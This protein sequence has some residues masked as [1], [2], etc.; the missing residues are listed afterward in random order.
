[1]QRNLERRRGTAAEYTGTDSGCRCRNAVLRSLVFAAVLVAGC[2][3]AELPAFS[4]PSA[5]APSFV[6]T[7]AAAFWQELPEIERAAGAP[8]GRARLELELPGDE[9]REGECVRSRVS[10]V[11][12]EGASWDLRV[13]PHCSVVREDP[14]LGVAIAARSPWR[15][16]RGEVAPESELE[17]RNADGARLFI[18]TGAV[19]APRSPPFAAWSDW[20]Y[21]RTLVRERA[22]TFG[23]DFELFG[24]TDCERWASMPEV[25]DVCWSSRGGPLSVLMD[26]T[27]P[28]FVDGDVPVC[29]PSE[30]EWVRRRVLS[31]VSAGSWQRFCGRLDGDH[32]R[33]DCDAVEA[34]IEPFARELEESGVSLPRF[35]AG[36]ALV[37]GGR[38]YPQLPLAV[39]ATLA[40]CLG[41]ARA[42]RTELERLLADAELD[43]ANRFR[44]EFVG[45]LL[46]GRH[47]G[48]SE[49][50]RLAPVETA[51]P[52]LD[53][54]DEACVEGSSGPVSF[55]E[56]G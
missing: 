2:G 51:D 7:H 19:W 40:E 10:W 33:L 6:A 39:V 16:V 26:V 20:L 47:P 56:L 44:L 41:Q 18:R 43:V 27:V 1:M 30:E 48:V 35:L 32:L 36:A 52:E 8:F 11:R 9:C 14:E 50:R 46:D 49:L 38:Y 45:A 4:E 25:H 24:G 28:S 13:M 53:A 15:V 34:R 54:A 29:V 42:L 21:T 3:E 17:L 12:F 55:C 22:R 31:P 37:F 5:D 23:H